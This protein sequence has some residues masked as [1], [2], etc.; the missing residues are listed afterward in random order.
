MKILYN[1]RTRG[2]GVEGVHIRGIVGG[3][4]GLGHKVILVSLPGAECDKTVLESSFAKMWRIISH[5]AP[6]AI[7]ELLEIAY[8]AI[9]FI[10]L[11]NIIRKEKI[12]FIYERYALFNFSGVT[13]AGIYKIPIILEINDISTLDRVRKL[14]MRWFA[15]WFEKRIFNS[16][17]ALIT[18]STYFKNHLIERGVPADKIWVLPNAVDPSVFNPK[19]ADDYRIRKQ[20]KFNGDVVVGFV[21]R[22][23]HWHGIDFLISCIPDIISATKNV[24]FMFVGGGNEK[25]RSSFMTH[26]HDK[27]IFDSITFTGWVKHDL[28][29]AYIAAMDITIIPNSNAYGSPMKLFEYMAMGKAVIVPRLG[30]IEDVVIDG[31]NCVMFEP[32]DKESLKNALQGLIKDAG[33]RARIGHEALKTVQENYT[34]EK[35]AQKIIEIGLA[36]AMTGVN[37]V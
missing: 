31:R 10:R 1:H 8:N 12:N 17:S 35:N 36:V 25:A 37:K 30:P 4:R 13:I 7:F 6:E 20:Y 15:G 5:N 29:P 22:F 3:L 24:R 18:I 26:I 28:I 2:K 34:W 14:R 21:G 9:S 27:G 32:G 23:A 19:Q 11:W 16:A 33:K